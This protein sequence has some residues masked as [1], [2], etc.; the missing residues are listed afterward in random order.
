MT[1]REVVP[2][3]YDSTKVHVKLGVP[4]PDKQVKLEE[5]KKCFPY[6]T[7]L[8]VQIVQGGL[9]ACSGINVPAMGD[10]EDAMVVCVAAVTVGH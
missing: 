9:A 6:G 4:M 2:G 5:I 3:G 8:D 7:V 1:C 10:A